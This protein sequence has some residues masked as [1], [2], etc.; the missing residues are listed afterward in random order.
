[1][2]EKPGRN[3]V[4]GTLHWQAFVKYTVFSKSIYKTQHLGAVLNQRPSKSQVLG[5]QKGFSTRLVLHRS[6]QRPL[7]VPYI[8]D[9][10]LK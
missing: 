3:H 8:V 7:H 9:C 10:E 1:M 6:H 4:A 5:V 2:K